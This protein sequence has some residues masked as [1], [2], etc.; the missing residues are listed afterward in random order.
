WV[1]VLKHGPK[2]PFAGFFDIDWDPPTPGLQN[3]VLLPVLEDHYCKVLEH[4]KLRVVEENGEFVISYHDHKF[5]IYSEAKSS[6]K[7][8][9]LL[10]QEQHYRLAYWRVGLHEINYRRFFDI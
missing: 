2:S 4:G 5:P 9:H 8:V 10:L 3:K 7:H 6:L 1:D